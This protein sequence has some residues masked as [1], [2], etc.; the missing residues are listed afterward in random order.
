MD[1]IGNKSFGKGGPKFPAG[2]IPGASGLL[3]ALPARVTF[4]TARPGLY[5]PSTYRK[6]F[7]LGLPDA[8]VVGGSLQQLVRAQ[9]RDRA[10]SQS[11]MADMRPLR[12][13]RP[14]LP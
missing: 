11:M 7:A 6:L 9:L 2:Q 8:T 14:A 12:R 1:G 5:L 10:E 4:L 13:P 3:Q